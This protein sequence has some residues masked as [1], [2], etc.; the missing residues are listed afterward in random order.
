MIPSIINSKLVENHNGQCSNTL[1]PCISISTEMTWIGSRTYTGRLRMS[2]IK[3][4][5]EISM[6]PAN[7]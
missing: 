4:I 3:L 7:T 6:A 1:N 2:S 5:K